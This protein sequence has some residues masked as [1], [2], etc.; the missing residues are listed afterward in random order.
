MPFQK[1]RIVSAIPGGPPAI[2]VTSVGWAITVGPNIVGNNCFVTYTFTFTVSDFCHGPPV[3]CEDSP[4]DCGDTVSANDPYINVRVNRGSIILGG[5]WGFAFGPGAIA[6]GAEIAVPGLPQVGAADIGVEGPSLLANSSL[7][8]GLRIAAFSRGHDEISKLFTST[9]DPS[10]HAALYIAADP[11]TQ[12]L[13]FDVESPEVLVFV[14]DGHGQVWNEQAFGGVTPE[15][16]GLSLGPIRY[17]NVN[18][19]AP[20]AQAA[21][22]QLFY[23]LQGSTKIMHATSSNIA[24]ARLFFDLR[25]SRPVTALALEDRGVRGR[26]DAEDLILYSVDGSSAIYMLEHG[27]AAHYL[28]ANGYAF[29]GETKLSYEGYADDPAAPA[30]AFRLGHVTA[31]SVAS[32]QGNQIT[33]GDR[34]I[35]DLRE[36]NP[37]NVDPNWMSCPA[38]LTHDGMVDAADLRLIIEASNSMRLETDLDGSAFTDANDLLVLLG[39]WGA[40][41]R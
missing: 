6:G 26:Y 29:D 16:S 21:D 35:R 19:A 1:C 31:L 4:E 39:N 34:A 3:T 11:I 33:P 7:L 20:D 41:P 15:G 37:A 9:L 18:T 5:G 8:S 24:G 23:V 30:P 38:D 2:L 22:E 14:I 25:T 32:G 10:N 36:L 40:C 13:P 12:V 17:L 27:G 28:T